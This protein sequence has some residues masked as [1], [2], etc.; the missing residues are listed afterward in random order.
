MEFF[1]LYKD[2]I[3][4]IIIVLLIMTGLR[5]LTNFLF[6]RLALRA[7]KKLSGEDTGTF[8]FVK[9]IVNALWLV[10]G[11]IIIFYLSTPEDTYTYASLTQDFKL[12]IYLGLVAVITIVCASTVNIWFK[13]IILKK[14][15]NNS[16]TTNLRFFRYIIIVSIYL[17]GFIMAIMVFPSLRG[18]AQTALGGAGIVAVV[19]AIASQEALANVVSGIFIISFRPFKVGDIIEV[20]NTMEGTVVDITLRHTVIRSFANKMIVIPNAIINKEKLVN[21][22]MG[23]LKCC[24]R[25][26]IGIAYNSD[27]DLAKR[28]MQEECENHP[29]ILDN[30]TEVEKSEDFPIVKTAV[31]RL[32]DFS[33]TIRAWAWVSN[34]S[35]AFQLRWDVYERVKKRFDTDGIEIPFP[36]RTV[37]VRQEEDFKIKMV[38]H[39]PNPEEHD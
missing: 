36:Y 15:L 22:T 20:G 25:L 9:R 21:A 28:I 29:L 30:R 39:L 27:I 8:N 31:T 5:F 37:V 38:D 11:I 1:Q 32:N 19:V 33:M 6:K 12:V 26:E 10:L 2:K 7:R 18:I 3:I 14:K 34:Y 16:D 4:Y 13:H 23:E 17:V 24:E 35:D